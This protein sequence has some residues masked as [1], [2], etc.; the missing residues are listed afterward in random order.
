[1][2]TRRFRS[3]A[4]L[5]GCLGSAAIVGHAAVLPS[6]EV[7]NTYPYQPDLVAVPAPTPAVATTSP[8]V[9]PAFRADEPPERSF[10][11]MELAMARQ[12]DQRKESLWVWEL[13]WNTEL[14]VIGRPSF[15]EVDI[16][17]SPMTSPTDITFS[18]SSTG[19][20]S[21]RLQTNVPLAT[22]TW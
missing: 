18:P 1:M 8:I 19:S 14:R 12:R 7:L 5:L 20:V 17:W 22:I 15:H 10:K 9:D 16:P 4:C 21:N 3:V 2:K 6:Q 13:R 11:D